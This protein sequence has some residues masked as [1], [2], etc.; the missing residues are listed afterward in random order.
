MRILKFDAVIYEF[1]TWAIFKSCKLQ[2]T[3]QALEALVVKEQSW[4][5]DLV[6]KEQFEMFLI[7]LL[8]KSDD[9]VFMFA[10]SVKGFSQFS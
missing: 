2:Q 3:S 5:N 9:V 10:H 7:C 4:P 1:P 6:L 8:A